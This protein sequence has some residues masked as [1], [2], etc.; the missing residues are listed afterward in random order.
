MQRF[1]KISLVEKTE[2]IDY[3]YKSPTFTESITDKSF[4]I[5][6][7]QQL[8][9]LQRN[10]MTQEDLQHYDFKD[11]KDTGKPVPITRKQGIDLAEIS[12]A[13]HNEQETIKETI[14]KAIKTEKLKQQLKQETESF[15]Q[16]ITQNTIQKS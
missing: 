13:I 6:T 7:S 1:N 16:E 2:K 15:K 4:F 8:Q 9:G 5:P 11:G 12:T 3:Q 14:N 10:T